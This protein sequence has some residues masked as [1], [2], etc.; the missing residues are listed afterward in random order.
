[1]WDNWHYGGLNTIGLKGVSF[2]GYDAKKEL[3]KVSVKV[4]YMDMQ[5]DDTQYYIDCSRDIF[6]FFIEARQWTGIEI[7]R[8]NSWFRNFN[9]AE[10]GEYYACK[11]LNCIIGYSESDISRMLSEGIDRIMDKEAILPLLNQRQFSVLQSELEFAYRDKMKH[12]LFVPLMA[13]GAPGESS[14]QMMRVLTQHFKPQIQQQFSSA[15]QEDYPCDVM[16][17]V[18]DC[19][20][21]GDQFAEFWENASIS[22]G[23]LLREWC[24][25][26]KIKVYYLCLVAY[27][28]TVKSLGEKYTDVRIV[29][30][31]QLTEKHKVF[32]KRNAVWDNEEEMNNA[33]RVVN[34]LVTGKE[35]PVLGYKELGFAVIIHNNIPD[36]SLPILYKAKNG[37][38]L[39]VERKDSND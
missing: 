32:N 4:T 2:L 38:N 33:K 1:M 24:S 35:I 21:S 13:N 17:I 23:M 25:K 16:V 6:E 14:N 27:D 8:L 37:W 5:V 19:V 18:D 39:L 26:Q 31:E 15:I 29:A 28:N 36:W 9:D 30:I 22:N 7:N 12:T 20:G 34:E 3:R 10:D 11:I